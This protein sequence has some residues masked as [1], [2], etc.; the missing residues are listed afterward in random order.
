MQVDNLRLTPMVWELHNT[1]MDIIPLGLT[2]IPMRKFQN[3]YCRYIKSFFNK[4]TETQK[5][6]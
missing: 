2:A 1:D 4:Y 3:K 5:S 6:I